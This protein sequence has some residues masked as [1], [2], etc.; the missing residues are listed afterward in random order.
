MANAT[1]LDPIVYTVEQHPPISDA[2]AACGLFADQGQYRV[3]RIVWIVGVSPQSFK[4][5][6]AISFRHVAKFLQGSAVKDDLYSSSHRRC[7]TAL[8]SAAT[9]SSS[10]AFAAFSSAAFAS[11]SST[12]CSTMSAPAMVWSV[13]P[14]R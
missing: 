11:T 10:A 6:R 3:P 12:I 8:Y 2:Q 5:P 7:Y 9:F 1:H 13:L 14:A 4:N